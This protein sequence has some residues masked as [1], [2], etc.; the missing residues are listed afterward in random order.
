MSA[1][2]PAQ[3]QVISLLANGSTI[4]AAAEAAGVHRNSIAHWR[5]TLPTFA[6]ALADAHY[7]RILHWRGLAE[8][9]AALAIDTIRDLLTDP[10]TPAGIRL[11]AALA[12]LK[13]CTTPPPTPPALAARVHHDDETFRRHAAHLVATAAV[14]PDSEPLCTPEEPEFVHNSAQSPEPLDGEKPRTFRHA[15]P[16]TGRNDACPC[17]SGQKYKRCCLSSLSAG[18]AAAA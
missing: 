1:L 9:H 12:L 3:D 4:S 13:E 5:R 18:T 15:T 11:R 14:V 8:E 2:T 6:A 7:D 10:K 16:K 17:G